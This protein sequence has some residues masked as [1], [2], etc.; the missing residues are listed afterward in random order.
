MLTK[1]TMKD[2]NQVP[3]KGGSLPNVKVRLTDL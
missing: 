3:L 2:P 1:K